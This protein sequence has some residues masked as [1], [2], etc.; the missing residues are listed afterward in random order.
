MA[1]LEFFVVSEDLSVDQQ[2]NRLSLFNIFEQINAH[3][4]PLVLPSITAV[5]VWIIEVGEEEKDF[6]CNL[7]IALP[8]ERHFDFPTNFK[9][10]SR[11]HR[12]IQRLQGLVID[13]PGMF[14]FKV[15]LNGDYI[16]SHEVDVSQINPNELPTTIE[17]VH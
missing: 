10:I 5:S 8:D 9:F 4:F 13:K 7:H 11:R 12:V 16:A 3:Q 2:T 15:F 6:Q 17:R 1:R 14:H